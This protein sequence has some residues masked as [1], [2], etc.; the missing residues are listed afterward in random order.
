MESFEV[1][2]EVYQAFADAHFDMTDIARRY[3]ARNVTDTPMKW[4]LDIKLCNK[5]QLMLA[6]VPE[7]NIEMCSIDTMTDDRFY[8]ARREGAATGRILSGI[9]LR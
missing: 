2:D 5:Q 6:G 9:V 1:G 8:S 7:E 3:P 4:H